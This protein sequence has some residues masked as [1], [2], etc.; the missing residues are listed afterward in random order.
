MKGKR[1]CKVSGEIDELEKF[2]ENADI[3]FMC[4][5]RKHHHHVFP[6]QDTLVLAA[7][8]V[9][10]IGPP[11]VSSDSRSSQGRHFLIRARNPEKKW[12]FWCMGKTRTYGYGQT[13]V[14]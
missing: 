10:F 13:W 4:G 11:S 8:V 2:A 6:L 12:T 9:P 3:T 7:E 5:K 14:T 1:E